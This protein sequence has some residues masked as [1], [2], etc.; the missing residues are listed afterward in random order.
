[1]PASDRA[2]RALARAA[3]GTVLALLGALRPRALPFSSA[4]PVQLQPTQATALPPDMDTDWLASLA[5]DELCHVECQGYHDGGFPQ[6]LTK[7]HL[8]HSLWYWPRRVHTFAIW[9]IRP[10]E[11]QRAQ[12]LVHHGITVRVSSLIVPDVP[13]ER[14]LRDPRTACFAPAADSR[15]AT[16]EVIC[17]RVARLLREGQATFLEWHMAVVAARMHSQRRYKV[18]LD[19]MERNG[20]EPILIEDLIKIG[21]DDG[22]EEGLEEGLEKGLEA[23]RRSTLRESIAMVLEARGIA[24]D[25]AQRARIAA[26]L[27]VDRL[28]A[29]MRRA[30]LAP[31]ARALFDDG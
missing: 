27:D 3:P 9:L 23:G 16:D 31:D 5:N 14:L 6:R 4:Q 30:A 17:D 15:G 26:E 2:F 22:F 12:R 29:W 28:S 21:R 25:D 20:Q 19:A 13:V 8:R 11:P 10:P 24:L 18:M 1:M 7:Y